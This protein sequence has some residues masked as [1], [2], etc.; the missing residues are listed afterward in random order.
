MTKIQNELKVTCPAFAQDGQIPKRH[1]GFGE[2][3]SPE[4]RLS[5][6]P[7]AAKSLAVVMD[8]LDIPL[9]GELNHWVIWNLPASETIEGSIPGGADCQNGARQGVG[10]GKHRYRGPKQPPF[11]K[12]EHRY[13]FTVY[14][15]DGV[16]NLPASSGKADLLRAMRGRILARGEL[17]GRYKP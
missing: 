3:A 15:L 11:I 12:K 5:G 7:E 6:L 2:D 1:T 13:R 8:D 16:L 4:L 9:I 10:Y 17:V 14:A